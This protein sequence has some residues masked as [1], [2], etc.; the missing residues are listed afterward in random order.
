MAGAAPIFADLRVSVGDFIGVWQLHHKV[1]LVHALKPGTCKKQLTAFMSPG[2]DCA[3]SPCSASLPA[4]HV[5]QHAR[6]SPVQVQ[7]M[8]GNGQ[9]ED[10]FAETRDRQAAAQVRYTGDASACRLNHA[11]VLID[12]L[13]MTDRESRN[14][15]ITCKQ[16]S[17]A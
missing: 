3:L 13:L 17:G 12:G 2:H 1:L 5:H 16:Q 9:K 10:G 15:P 11:C 6:L 7:R 8:A 14:I 4:G